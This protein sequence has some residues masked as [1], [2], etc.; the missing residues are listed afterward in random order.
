[1]YAYVGGRFLGYYSGA[2]RVG[3]GFLRFLDKAVYGVFAAREG[4]VVVR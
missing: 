3:F 2:E 4:Y 1:M